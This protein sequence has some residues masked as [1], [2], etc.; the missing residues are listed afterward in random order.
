LGHQK[1][2]L[3]NHLDSLISLN[4]KEDQPLELTHHLL[5]LPLE[6]TPPHKSISEALKGSTKDPAVACFL[7][8]SSISLNLQSIAMKEIE[9]G[10]SSKLLQWASEVGSFLTERYSSPLDLFLVT[11]QSAEILKT[12]LSKFSK[13]LIFTPN[14][15]TKLEKDVS[16]VSLLNLSYEDHLGA[17]S[18]LLLKKKFLKKY[19]TLIC[20]E[21]LTALRLFSLMGS[22]SNPLLFKEITAHMTSLFDPDKSGDKDKEKEKEKEKD[23]EKDKEKEKDRDKPWRSFISHL[24]SAIAGVKGGRGYF[25]RGSPTLPLKIDALK[26]GSVVTCTNFLCCLA[27]MD[28]AKRFAEGKILYE[29]FLPQEFGCYSKEVSFLHLESELILPPFTSFKVLS[30]EQGAEGCQHF[31]KLEC[32]GILPSPISFVPSSNMTAEEEQA[33]RKMDFFVAAHEGNALY[34]ILNPED[35][36]KLARER[37]EL[38]ENGLHVAS[39]QGGN[40]AILSALLSHGASLDAKDAHGNTP[41]HVAIQSRNKRCARILLQRGASM[42]ARNAQGKSPMDENPDFFASVLS[43]TRKNESSSS[44]DFKKTRKTSIPVKKSESSYVLPEEQMGTLSS[45]HSSSSPTLA[46]MDQEK[47]ER[48]DLV[49]S[50]ADFLTVIAQLDRSGRLTREQTKEIR[51]KVMKED[52]SILAAFQAYRDDEDLLL[53]TLLDYLDA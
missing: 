9:K 11:P 18:G 12:K 16:Q 26:A 19:D 21:D 51:K 3:S 17:V 52:V 42:D 47:K 23:K 10:S 28:A 48:G 38:N 37:N 43:K 44:L 31:L 22:E 39:R 32:L 5:N 53:E 7:A 41:L 20:P 49:S 29:I 50:R 8:I 15:K 1:Y 4:I 6:Q 2:P 27:H 35:T 33:K 14:T 34:F 46:S 36:K 40:E 45:N 30:S 25:Y 13:E 24:C